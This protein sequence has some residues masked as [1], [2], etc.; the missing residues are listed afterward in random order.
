MI[1]GRFICSGGDRDSRFCGEIGDARGNSSR[2]FAGGGEIC[3]IVSRDRL[4]RNTRSVLR[5]FNRFSRVVTAFSTATNRI[6]PV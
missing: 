5:P 1:S 4:P 2:H 6:I 3:W